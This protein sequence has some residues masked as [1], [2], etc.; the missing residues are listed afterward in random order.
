MNEHINDLMKQ[1]AEYTR[2]KEE[3]DAIISSIQDEIKEYM[4]E[5]N[6]EEVT[7]DEH[8]ARII[9]V[10]TTRLDSGKLKKELSDV[11]EKYSKP[12]SYK[13]FLFK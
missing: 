7:S 6:V 12:S 5:H 10:S 3:V 11:Y 9:E 4:K 8:K 1:L 2:I 13:K